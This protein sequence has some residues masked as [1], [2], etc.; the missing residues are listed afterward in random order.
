MLGIAALNAAHAASNQDILNGIQKIVD[1]DRVA[2]QFPAL[3]VS[4]ILPGETTPHDFASG[5][6]TLSGSTLVKPNNLFQIGSE[7]KSFTAATILLLEAEGR[8][9]INDAIGKW[10]PNLPSSWNNITIKQ[11]LNHTSGIFNFTES[12]EWFDIA[13]KSNFQKQWAPEELINTVITKPTYFAPGKGYHYSNTNYVLAG[14][15]IRAASGKSVDDA[16][17][18]Y[19]FKPLQLTNTYYASGFFS[20][21]ILSRIAHGYS[22]SGSGLFPDEPKDI[23]YLNHSYTQTAGSIVST[24]H[25]TTKW[26]KSLLNGSFLPPKQMSELT[27]LISEEDGQP[28]PI[29]D[30]KSGYG[31]GI[32]SDFALGEEMWGHS[33]G[34]IGYNTVM[35]WLKC[36]DTV[37]AIAVS[38]AKN[39]EGY[40]SNDVAID[41]ISFIQK[42]DPSKQCAVITDHPKK[43]KELFG[44]NK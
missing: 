21:D 12:E 9:S 35:I 40:S 28:I 7:T 17:N 3:Q 39:D 2:Y 6:T 44:N 33:G 4:V 5:T 11:I 22:K 16:L 43:S 10:I 1:Q 30:K 41:I 26:L 34:T 23:T 20:E 13:M 15:I 14:M 27:S 8:L 42:L 31:L 36:R 37:I 29:T 18:T 38:D 32:G 25:D 19:L 24:T